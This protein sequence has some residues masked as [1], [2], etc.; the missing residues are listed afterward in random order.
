MDLKILV[1]LARYHSQRIP[2][3]VS[4]CLF[5][6]T[7]NVVTLDDAIAFERKAISAWQEIVNA[8]G[9]TYAGDLTMG[10]RMKNLCG[11]WKDELAELQNGLKGLEVQRQAMPTGSG[12]T[13]LGSRATWRRFRRPRLRSCISQF[14]RPWR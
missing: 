8:A 10:R 1:G 2:A 3:A 4:Y 11:H 7:K 14:L 12:A 13:G 9:D 6:Q 5:D